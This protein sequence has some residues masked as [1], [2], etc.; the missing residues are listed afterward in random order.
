MN[1]ISIQYDIYE[2][3]F[4]PETVLEICWPSG[5]T[6][7][8]DDSTHCALVQSILSIKSIITLPACTCQAIENLILNS[9]NHIAITKRS[10]ADARC[11][12]YRAYKEA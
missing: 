4:T 6:H 2:D 7:D 8:T 10:N 5:A 1:P 3:P 12:N 11:I 9:P